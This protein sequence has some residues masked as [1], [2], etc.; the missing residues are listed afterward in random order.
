M[1]AAELGCSG[2]LQE[3]TDLGRRAVL[4]RIQVLS[5]LPSLYKHRLPRRAESPGYMAPAGSQ[6]Q[7]SAGALSFIKLQAAI[8]RTKAGVDTGRGYH[9]LPSTAAELGERKKKKSLPNS[10]SDES[11]SLGSNENSLCGMHIK[12]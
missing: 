6:R 12:G 3:H 9:L 8:S 11:S 4:P 1:G 10:H 2:I 5:S 7:L